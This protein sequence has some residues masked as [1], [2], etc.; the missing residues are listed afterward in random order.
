VRA[1]LAV[2]LVLAVA[3]CTDDSA[4]S[5]ASTAAVP[6]TSTTTTAAPVLQG[7][8]LEYTQAFTDGATRS[9]EAAAA[10]RKAFLQLEQDVPDEL[11]PDVQTFIGWFDELQALYADHDNDSAAIM[12]DPRFTQLFDDQAVIDANGRIGAWLQ[13]ECAAP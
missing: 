3:G 13:A 11:R 8:C 9:P 6:V 7:R 10:A 12:A 5:P 2:V 1:V 4:G